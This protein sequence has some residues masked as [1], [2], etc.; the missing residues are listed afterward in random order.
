MSTSFD[1]ITDIK[2]DI[3]VLCHDSS[4]TNTDCRDIKPNIVCECDSTPTADSQQFDLLPAVCKTDSDDVQ[5]D[6]KPHMCVLC[7]NLQLIICDEK[8][9]QIP[10]VLMNEFDVAQLVYP[11]I[12]KPHAN[13]LDKTNILNDDPSYKPYL[14]IKCGKGLHSIAQW[15]NHTMLHTRVK[16]FNC[17]VC[18]QQFLTRQHLLTHSTTRC[19]ARL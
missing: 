12:Q 6:Q 9:H 2:P 16:Q 3:S 5:F 8:L 19:P 1:D 11:I 17:S 10:L 14:C 15:R 4:T 18:H 7:D 13:D